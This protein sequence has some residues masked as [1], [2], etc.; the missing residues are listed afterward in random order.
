LQ[1][2][3]NITN[4]PEAIVHPAAIAGVALGII[5]LSIILSQ[6]MHFAGP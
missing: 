1:D 5:T 3:N 2:A 4:S 6:P